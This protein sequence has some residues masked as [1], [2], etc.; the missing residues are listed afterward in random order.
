MLK[1]QTIRHAEKEI[2]RYATTNT[3]D[4]QKRNIRDMLNTTKQA[5]EHRFPRHAKH[6][7][8]NNKNKALGMPT[9][10][11]LDILKTQILDILEM[12]SLDIRK[13]NSLDILKTD[14]VGILRTTS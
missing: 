12:S 4:I 9:T 14:T 10:T 2:P 1:Q 3:L 8:K 6:T 13:V 7:Q 5:C 11:Q